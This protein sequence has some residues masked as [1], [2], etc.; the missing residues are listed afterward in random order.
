MSPSKG[1]EFKSEEGRGLIL[2]EFMA[3]NQDL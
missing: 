3:G 1:A 2:P